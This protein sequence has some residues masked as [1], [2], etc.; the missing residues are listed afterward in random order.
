MTF[1]GPMIRSALHATAACV[2]LLGM[3]E[4]APA[5]A[6]TATP[7]VT[8]TASGLVRGLENQ[9][10]RVFRG[11]PYAAPPVG[12]NRWKAPQPVT[13]WLGLRDATAFAS[14]CPQTLPITSVQEDCLYLNVYVPK[15]AAPASRL[16]VM[17]WVHGGAYVSGTGAFYDAANM[18]NLG[19]VVVVT[20]N[21]RL[22]ALGFLALPQ[23]KAEDPALDFGI[24]DQQAA[25]KWV[26][27]NIAPFGGDKDRVTLFGESAGAASTCAN[28][29]S[30][31]ASGLFHRAIIQSGT[32]SAA[33]AA[34]PQA[35]A[36]A[37][38]Q[39]FVRQ[40]GC[41][42]EPDQL[43]CLRS[44]PVSQ[45]LAFVPSTVPSGSSDASA[46]LPWISVIDGVVIPE[47]PLSAIKARRAAK[48][49]VMLGTNQNEGSLY[50]A[51][52][53]DVPLGRPMNDNEY[54]AKLQS[55]G[56][57][58][59]AASV[60]KSIYNTKN[61][62]TPSRA[63][64]GLLTDVMFSCDANKAARA[65]ANSGVPTYAYEF[66][67]PSPPSVL[68]P[69]V[70][71][72]G[73]THASELQFLFDLNTLDQFTPDQ[74]VLMN[75]MIGY[76]TRFA[77][78]GDPNRTG[79][80]EWSRFNSF[81][82]PFKNLVPGGQGGMLSYGKFQAAHHCLLWDVLTSLAPPPGN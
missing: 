33:W 34:I 65:F 9:D 70:P 38:G 26:R 52:E 62:S 5:V 25:L 61:Y 24:Q 7:V 15:S 30:P 60:L 12:G 53:F 13:P 47:M 31:G 64:A 51:L 57:S 40:M 44:K 76:W 28:L 3:G 82:T 68:S 11:I 43:A 29:V 19:Q 59:F 58:S 36:Y 67:D 54:E 72:M 16:P 77:A 50:V 23:L 4:L 81:S 10:G 32:C 79:L 75:Q 14:A 78:T 20:I 18:A 35:R 69:P 46:L 74:K 63:V 73:A 17:V 2:A 21:Y 22:G 41:A 1:I 71:D 8:A 56:G 39:D 66:A 45:L 80:P 37:T 48:V 42:D 6:Q 55:Y 27:A 49:P